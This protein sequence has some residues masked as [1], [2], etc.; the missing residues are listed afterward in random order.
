MSQ[1]TFHPDETNT[2]EPEKNRGLE[3][4]RVIH[5]SPDETFPEPGE[6]PLPE[7]SPEADSSGGEE[8][9]ESGDDTP[10][11]VDPRHE[12]IGPDI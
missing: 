11:I 7:S 10:G 6:L 9:S 3:D 1:S 4:P 8:E 5:P 2:P 12:T